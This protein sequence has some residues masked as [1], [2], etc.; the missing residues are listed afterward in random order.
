MIAAAQAHR[1]NDDDHDQRE[2][3]DDVALQFGHLLL[4][5]RRLILRVEDVDA[6]RNVR[7]RRFDDGAY[8]RDGVDDVRVGALAD[9]QRHRGFA[10]HARVADAVLERRMDLRDVA[11]RHDRVAFAF[12]RNV[13]DVLR[14]L[15]DARHLHGKTTLAGIERAGRDQP[16]V[17]DDVHQQLF[18]RD[19]IAL[20]RG[21]IDHRF[22]HLFAFAVQLGLEHFGDRFDVVA[23]L[24]RDVVEHALGDVVAHQVDLDDREVVVGRFLHDGLFCGAGDF[25]LRAVDRV[26]YVDRCLGERIVGVELDDDGARAFGGV[27]RHLLDAFD[28]THFGFDRHHE[29]P[30][31]VFRRNAL[32]RDRHDEERDFDVRFGFDEDRAVRG[33][34]GDH[35]HRE[36][37]QRGA[38]AVDRGINDCV[39]RRVSVA[40][41]GA[42]ALADSA[43][44]R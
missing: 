40:L 14:A 8:L 20:E 42:E 27:R 2:R 25:R 21:R 4:G 34:T 41:G 5:E 22:E 18:V 1:C 44:A 37:Q 7:A 10:V 3:R 12:H 29:Q 43:W 33:D 24:N 15:D 35:D 13:E 17:V 38:R 39:H 19:V 36:D 16:V 32:V 6:A 23:Q 11:Q 30:L 9:V 26:A 31:G 28:R